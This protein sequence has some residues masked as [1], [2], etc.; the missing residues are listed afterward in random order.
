MRTVG[1]VLILMLLLYGSYILLWAAIGW[2]GNEYGTFIEM[3]SYLQQYPERDP[4]VTHE[5]RNRCV[6]DPTMKEYL[7]TSLYDWDRPHFP[8]VW[9]E[10]GRFDANVYHPPKMF[11]N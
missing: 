3:E 9:E 10:S 2:L 4:R 8:Y 5:V 6:R 7:D 1:I 11:P